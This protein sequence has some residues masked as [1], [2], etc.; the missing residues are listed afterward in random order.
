MKALIRLYSTCKILHIGHKKPDSVPV[1]SSNGLALDQI[2]DER[3][4][5]SGIKYFNNKLM[6]IDFSLKI[7]VGKLNND[8]PF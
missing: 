7:L 8:N 2:R 5:R 4:A 6:A 1:P 3:K